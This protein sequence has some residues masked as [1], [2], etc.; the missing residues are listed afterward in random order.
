MGG[1]RGPLLE[2]FVSP[3]QRGQYGDNLGASAVLVPLAPP[4]SP[5]IFTLIS[6]VLLCLSVA[7]WCV[8][9]RYD[10]LEI[11]PS[12][13]W[14]VYWGYCRFTKQKKTNVCSLLSYRRSEKVVLSVSMLPPPSVCRVF[15]KSNSSPVFLMH[16]H[17]CVLIFFYI[18]QRV[19]QIEMLLY[20]WR[21]QNPPPRTWRVKLLFLSFP[22]R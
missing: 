20:G 8:Q 7:A 19:L 18:P 15:G 16:N 14:C 22:W 10:G 6:W 3:R 17:L 9:E 1:C 21:W 2:E 12:S 11:S 5:S 4:R 13:A